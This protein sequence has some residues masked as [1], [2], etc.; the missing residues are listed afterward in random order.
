MCKSSIK[1]VYSCK[2]ITLSKKHLESSIACSCP[3][4]L[5]KGWNFSFL[6]FK[7]KVF[8]FLKDNAF[9]VHIKVWRKVTWSAVKLQNWNESGE[10]RRLLSLDCWHRWHQQCFWML[11]NVFEELLELFKNHCSPQNLSFSNI[12]RRKVGRYFELL[13]VIIIKDFL[14]LCFWASWPT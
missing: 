14:H 9:V 3:I 11:N 6:C 13:V 2:I 7:Q 4:F 10:F 5:L 1:P 8:A 12:S